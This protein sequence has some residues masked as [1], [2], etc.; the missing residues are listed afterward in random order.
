MVAN[1]IDIP[2]PELFVHSNQKSL[3]FRCV[4]S[5]NFSAPF[6]RF[7]ATYYNTAWFVPNVISKQK[8]K[9]RS[10][11]LFLLIPSSPFVFSSTYVLRILILRSMLITL[12]NGKKVFRQSRSNYPLV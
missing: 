10:R 8:K 1:S 6:S 12:P 7:S 5:W 11:P 2:R 9:K 3:S 4:W